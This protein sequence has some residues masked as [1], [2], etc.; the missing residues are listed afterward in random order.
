MV[1]IL[2]S[3]TYSVFFSENYQLLHEYRCLPSPFGLTFSKMR[4][5]KVDILKHEGTGFQA[6]LIRLS[7][8]TV[9]MDPNYCE[10]F[11]ENKAFILR[12]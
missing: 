5:Q 6:N 11:L 2:H 9:M 10:R 1:F 12:H 3:L 7:K 8:M 4:D